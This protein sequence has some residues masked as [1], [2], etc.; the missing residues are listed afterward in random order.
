MGRPRA[1][2]PLDNTVAV[3]L[4]RAD[5]RRFY[6]YV[7]SLA[8]TG[9]EPTAAEVARRIILERLDSAAKTKS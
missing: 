8:V 5:F 9:H 4:R 7:R 2:D 3:R 6:A 1:L